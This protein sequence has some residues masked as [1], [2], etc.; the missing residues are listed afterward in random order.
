[1][2]TLKEWQALKEW[3]VVV[4]ALEDGEQ[5]ILFR[6]GG[7]LDPGFS[8]ESS[9]FLLFPTF[10]HQTKE[11]LKENYK[12]NTFIPHIS[13]ARIRRLHGK[14]DVLA[15]LNSVYS[16]IDLEVN[17]ISMYESKLLPEG[18]QYTIINTFPLN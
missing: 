2:Q 13:I 11:Y 4:K 1:M 17:S 9:E 16:P 8:V 3:A 18:A 7:I 6:K 10:E 15:F 14:I 12:N 5:Y